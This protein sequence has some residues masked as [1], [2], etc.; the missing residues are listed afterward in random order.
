MQYYSNRGIQLELA[1]PRKGTNSQLHSHTQYEIGIVESG[2]RR[3]FIHKDLYHVEAGDVVLIRPGCPHET[4]NV[5]DSYSRYLIYF[6]SGYITDP[7]LLSCFDDA[8]ISLS[9][10]RYQDVLRVIEKMRFEFNNKDTYAE[11]GVKICLEQLL[12]LFCRYRASQSVRE[13]QFLDKNVQAAARYIRTHYRENI[14]LQMIADEVYL[15]PSYLSKRFKEVTGFGI[16]EYISGTRL[17]EAELLLTGSDK[18]IQEIAD[19]CGFNDP[20]YFGDA[21]KKMKGISPMQ[22]RRK[23]KVSS[24]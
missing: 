22:F 6:S 8:V 3:Y 21:F 5:S 14:T 13:F 18:S 4:I 1:A 16:K 9:Q 12:I 7:I 15:S 24:E 17:R 23:K 2:D 10:R 11:M 20:N 19:A